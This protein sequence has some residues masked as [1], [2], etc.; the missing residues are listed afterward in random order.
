MADP[1]K[2][3]LNAKDP[4]GAQG[5]ENKEDGGDEEE[6]GCCDKFADCIKAVC[7]VIIK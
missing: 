7:K 4:A 1:E 3:P 2:Q 6:K 5:E